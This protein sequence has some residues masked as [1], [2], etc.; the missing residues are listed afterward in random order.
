VELIGKVVLLGIV[1]SLI[2]TPVETASVALNR[3]PFRFVFTGNLVPKSIVGRHASTCI[4]IVAGGDVTA[5]FL[6][7]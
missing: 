7:V 4:H 1:E 5:E 6:R 2:A 3:S